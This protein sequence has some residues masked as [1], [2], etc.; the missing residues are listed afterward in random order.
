MK[1]GE[2]CGGGED[3][4]QKSPLFK[5]GLNVATMHNFFDERNNESHNEKAQQNDAE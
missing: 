4:Y 5:C 1:N 2:N 3:G